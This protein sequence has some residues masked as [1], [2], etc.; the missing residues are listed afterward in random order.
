MYPHFTRARFQCVDHKTLERVASYNHIPVDRMNYCVD[1]DGMGNVVR[2][3]LDAGMRKDPI[4]YPL[5]E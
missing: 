4:S 2:D 3:K 5:G 1:T